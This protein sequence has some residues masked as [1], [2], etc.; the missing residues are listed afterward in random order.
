MMQPA[1]EA[2]M[3]MVIK[4]WQEGF[5]DTEKE[6][7]DFFSAFSGVARTF[8]WKEEGR[9][10]GQLI[11]LPVTLCCLEKTA[12]GEKE[13]V[14]KRY[15]AEYIYA[16]T[17]SCAYR[18]RGISTKLLEAVSDMLASEEKC[19]VLVPAD[20]GLK[21]FY[22]SRGFRE[23]FVEEIITV[24]NHAVPKQK[25]AAVSRQKGRMRQELR[26]ADSAD[27]AG[28]L[29]PLTEEEYIRLR[30]EAFANRVHIEQPD[31]MVAYAL[32]LHK[33][34]GGYCVKIRCNGGS[35]GVLYR[36]EADGGIFIREITAGTAAEAVT[37]AKALLFKLGEQKAV[38]QRACYTLGLHLPGGYMP[39][40]PGFCGPF[41]DGYFNLVL[42]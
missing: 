18:N 27:S 30:K 3:P 19:A 16:V 15:A 6:I 13:A 25:T 42:D 4:N 7:A 12:D 34:E 24:E 29:L 8:V 21:A 39:D 32:R 20:E 36:V 28:V 17:T 33:K 14:C 26:A 10:A 35:C 41:A 38:L 23:C 11:L 1:K 37:A 5:G 31:A 40:G 2:D 9:A 22:E